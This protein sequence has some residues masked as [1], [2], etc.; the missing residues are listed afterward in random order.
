MTLWYN[1]PKQGNTI[2]TIKGSYDNC[3]SGFQFD[4]GM[5]IIDNNKV[6]LI[7][8]LSS[9]PTDVKQYGVQNLDLTGKQVLLTFNKTDYE[10]S[11]KDGD[12]YKKITVSPNELELVI[13]NYFTELQDNYDFKDMNFTGEINLY[14]NKKLL[15]SLLTGKQ[16]RFNKEI[17]LSDLDMGSLWDQLILIEP[18][19]PKLLIDSN[20]P[21]YNNNSQRKSYSQS[22]LLNQK[23]NWLVESFKFEQCDGLTDLIACSLSLSKE[24]NETFDV[25]DSKDYIIAIINAVLS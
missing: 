5:A 16:V 24:I 4:E 22:D 8:F 17:E 3:S 6:S 12:S 20:L 11:V 10:K 7:L 15:N 13:C 9:N 18:C 25:N 14:D 21:V 19:E 23:F 1:E 2:G